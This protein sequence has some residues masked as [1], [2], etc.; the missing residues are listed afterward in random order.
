M[1]E[2]KVRPAV[3]AD[4]PI[5]QTFEQGIIN[6]ERPFNDCLKPEHI[7]YY[8]IG[9]LI[10]GEGSTVMVAEDEGVLVGSG[11]ARIKESKAHLTHDLH[12]YLGFMYVAETHRGRGI[13]QMIIQSLINWG[14]AKGMEHFYLEAYAENNSALQAYEKM[15]FKASLVEMK[16]SY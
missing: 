10:A 14:K 4:L 5:L 12:A 3:S 2:I 15:G 16:L 13:N 9:A 8:D 1:S 11:Y 6:T 7:C